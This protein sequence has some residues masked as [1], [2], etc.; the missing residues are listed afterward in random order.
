MTATDG[1]HSHGFALLLALALC[2]GCG[3]GPGAEP[4]AF[5]LLAIGDAGAP[6]QAAVDYARMREVARA[7]A[8]EDIERPVDALVFLGDNFYP[9]GLRSAEL[10]ERISANL[11]QPFC[12]FIE[13]GPQLA[14]TDPTCD[15]APA[16][17]PILAVLG[18]HDYHSDESPG[19]QRDT[20]PEFIANWH[21]PQGLVATREFP[22]GVSLILFDAEAIA[23]GADVGPLVDAL[24]GSV[25]PWRILVGHRPIATLGSADERESQASYSAA[26]RGALTRSGVDVQLVLA[27]H[28]HRLA[29]LQMQ[30]PAPAL[31][32]IS[33]GGS[34][35]RK[36]RG[37]EPNL[38]TEFKS[39]GFVRVDLHGTGE[40]QELS[41]S[42][43]RVHRYPWIRWIDNRLLAARYSVDREGRVREN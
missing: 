3:P 25:G 20:V 41:V 16:A 24:R 26:I 30:A 31:H 27:G 5:S 17:V 2:S 39:L 9:S 32:A 34:E 36:R 11:T 19:L 22:A 13:P 33:G 21:M 28:E 38:R 42:I 15:R 10:A 8:D 4:I 12:R 6:P 18:N 29:I 35:R 23:A 40:D 1:S 14:P 37:D 43:L 7:M